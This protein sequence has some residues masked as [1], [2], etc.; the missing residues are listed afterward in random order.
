MYKKD[1]ILILLCI[2][3]FIKLFVLFEGIRGEIIS[4]W[5]YFFILE[6]WYC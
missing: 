1:F 6:N 2:F 5:N 4:F 3:Y